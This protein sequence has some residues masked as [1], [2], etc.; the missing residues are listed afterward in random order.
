MSPV[1]QTRNIIHALQ[2]EARGLRRE[3]GLGGERRGDAE[4]SFHNSGACLR[5]GPAGT[6]QVCSCCPGRER[7]AVPVI[8]RQQ[9]AEGGGEEEERSPL[10]EATT[11]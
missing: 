8:S 3:V 1:V 10:V 4:D 6:Q 11:P 7:H 5:R 9:E 2:R